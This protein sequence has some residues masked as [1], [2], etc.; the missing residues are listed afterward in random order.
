VDLGLAGKRAA[1]SAAT[2]GLG[3]AAATSLAREGAIVTIC[4]RDEDR[5]AAAAHAIGAHWVVCDLAR[6]GEPGRF[7][8]EAI[9]RMGGLDIL[10]AN[11]S[12]PPAGAADQVDPAAYRDAFDHLAGAAI[13]MCH[14]AV[15][16]MRAAGWGRVVAVTSVA[17]R[18][19]M[20]NLALSTVARSGLSAYLKALSF[21][22]A[23]DGVT[24]N[25]LQPGMHATFRVAEVYDAGAAARAVGDIP[26]GRMGD[27]ADFGALVAQLCSEQA[28]YL[29][30]AAI[31]VDGGLS[32]GMS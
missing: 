9:E 32:R 13:E 23:G 3:L 10:V 22:V 31:P 2:A 26:A 1:V 16:V 25:S 7:V 18:Y 14:R 28:S 27:P 19:S 8:D 11:T 5:A 21:E 4:G 17:V 30:G 29:T 6:A 15:P 20:P 12:G 24:V